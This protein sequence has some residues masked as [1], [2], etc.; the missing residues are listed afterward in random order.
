MNEQ[1]QLINLN[2]QV[3]VT[4]VG[5]S[6]EHNNVKWISDGYGKLENSGNP[7]YYSSNRSVNIYAYQPYNSAWTDVLNSSYDFTVQSDQTTYGYANSDLLWATPATSSVGDATARL[8][9]NHMLS[10]INVY[11]TNEDG[12]DVSDATITLKNVEKTAS[13]S[14]GVVSKRDGDI[15]DVI[16][17]TYTNCATAIVVPQTLRANETFIEIIQNGH[18]YEYK[19][20]SDRELLSGRLYTYRLKIN[21]NGMIVL[22]DSDVNPWIDGDED[23]S[24]DNFEF[25]KVSEFSSERKF[26]SVPYISGTTEFD[27]SG[28][29]W[30]ENPTK[31]FMDITVYYQNV[32]KTEISSLNFT[33]WVGDDHRQALTAWVNSFNVDKSMTSKFMYQASAWSWSRARIY[34]NTDNTIFYI[35]DKRNSMK[36][37]E[38]ESITTFTAITCEEKADPN[39]FSSYNHGC[40]EIAGSASS[41]TAVGAIPSWD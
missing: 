32:D 41:N 37:G 34:V 29:G 10:K 8:T 24:M 16:A 12:T 38:F 6:M 39:H 26:Y 9:F 4:I 25:V 36:A 13:F 19:S 3:G 11:L 14:N 7:I 1:E 20:T 30:F 18:T 21:S 28:S 2:Q 33:S 22:D 40:G 35:I 5:G 27:D 31:Y 23:F 15:G 17:G